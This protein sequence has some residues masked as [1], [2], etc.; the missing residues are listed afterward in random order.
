MSKYKSLEDAM[1]RFH[2]V[3]DHC[4]SV[5]IVHAWGKK[6]HKKPEVV[7]SHCQTKGCDGYNSEVL[8][9]IDEKGGVKCIHE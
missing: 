7:R 2:H 6:T 9:E 5:M 3:C 1:I 4:R 8:F